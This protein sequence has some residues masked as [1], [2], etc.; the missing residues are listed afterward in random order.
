M[1]NKKKRGAKTLALRD[2]ETVSFFLKL[3]TTI[4]IGD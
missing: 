4:K 1:K 3:I 2:I